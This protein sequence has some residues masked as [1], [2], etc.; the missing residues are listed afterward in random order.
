VGPCLI[1][2]P[3]RPPRLPV[4]K[5]WSQ[6]YLLLLLLL[7]PITD[8]L[9]ASIGIPNQNI[10]HSGASFIRSEGDTSFRVISWMQS[11]SRLGVFIFSSGSGCWSV[12]T[13]ISWDE[14][15]L[16]GTHLFIQE[17][18]THDCCF[19]YW[20]LDNMSMVFKNNA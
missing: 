17:Q 12:S 10:V 18:C 5:A 13:S 8:D 7:P 3:G 14:L 19:F 15:G 1:G 16:D 20:K 9:L 6:R 11:S 2:G 4:S